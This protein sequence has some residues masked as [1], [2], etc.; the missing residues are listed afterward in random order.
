MFLVWSESQRFSRRYFGWKIFIG[1]KHSTDGNVE[2]FYI[3]EC[4]VRNSL[5]KTSATHKHRPK[6]LAVAA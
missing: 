4:V 6:T 1:Q 2:M 3:N 5:I